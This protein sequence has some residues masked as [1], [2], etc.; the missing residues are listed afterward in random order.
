[1]RSLIYSFIVIA[2]LFSSYDVYPQGPP[3]PPVFL[4]LADSGSSHPRLLWSKVPTAQTY[5]VQIAM[6]NQMNTVVLD[7]SGIVDTFLTIPQ[8]LSYNTWYFLRLNYQCIWHRDMVTCI[9][10][11]VVA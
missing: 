7:S 2:V 10:I 4:G 6:D 3:P 1:M 8:T 9:S 5:R 11:C